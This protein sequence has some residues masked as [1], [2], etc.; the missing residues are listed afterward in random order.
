MKDIDDDSSE[1]P[2]KQ[3]FWG[4][5]RKEEDGE[6]LVQCNSYCFLLLVEDCQVL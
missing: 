1:Y 2:L 5:V 6:S 4:V 3:L